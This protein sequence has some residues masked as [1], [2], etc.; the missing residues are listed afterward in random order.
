MARV[1]L[2][3]VKFEVVPILIDKRQG[4]GKSTVT[5]RLLPDYHT[6]SE[7]TFGK[8]DSDYQKIQANAIIE[9]ALS[10]V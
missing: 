7:I 10:N 2:E 3:K 8:R 9:L 4:T 1:Y 5:K 6:D